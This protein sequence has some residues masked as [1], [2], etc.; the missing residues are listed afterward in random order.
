MWIGKYFHPNHTAKDTKKRPAHV[1]TFP[2]SFS[3][4]PNNANQYLDTD[5]NLGVTMNTDKIFVTTAFGYFEVSEVVQ[6]SM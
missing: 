5:S 1:L 3:P 2:K 6:Y 4:D